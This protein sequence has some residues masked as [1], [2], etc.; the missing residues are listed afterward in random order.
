MAKR[1]DPID[2]LVGQRVRAYRLSRGMS[3]SALGEKVG[4]TFQQIQKYERGANRMGGSRLK[5][6]ATILGVNVAA[7]FGEDE[8]AG[9][10]NIDDLLTEVLSQRYATRLLRAFGAIKDEKQ[11]LALVQ[12]AES[13]TPKTE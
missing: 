9:R 11:R 6:I 8:C 12:L 3:Q 4:V 5:K 1:I 7:F 13:M 2:V 10:E